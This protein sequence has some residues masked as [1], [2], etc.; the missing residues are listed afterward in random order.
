MGRQPE[1]FY[2][3]ISQNV[4]T[5][6]IIISLTNEN[7]YFIGKKIF[8]VDGSGRCVVDDGRTVRKLRKVRKLV[9]SNKV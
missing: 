4:G 3:K 5:V 1:P 2:L 8:I 6:M 9:A 7:L